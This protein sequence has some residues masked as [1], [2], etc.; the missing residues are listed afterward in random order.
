MRNC[1][2]VF[3][4]PTFSNA[5][6]LLMHGTSQAAC[7]RAASNLRLKVLWPVVF[8]LMNV[9][10]LGAFSSTLRDLW[11]AQGVEVSI[12]RDV[13]H[14]SFRWRMYFDLKKEEWRATGLMASRLAFCHGVNMT[15]A[16]TRR[17]C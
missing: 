3:E 9:I 12:R 15:F 2:Y 5:I 4:V 1:K 17:R 11:R 14:P 6:R 13:K 8:H 10:C 16:I 7:D